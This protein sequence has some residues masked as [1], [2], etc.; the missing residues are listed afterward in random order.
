MEKIKE[1]QSTVLRIKYFEQMLQ[2]K[3]EKLFFLI[4]KEEYKFIITGSS[5]IYDYYPKSNKILDRNTN[6]W[7]PDG[8][9]YIESELLK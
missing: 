1:K 9:A 3:L 4:D 7:H 8:A 5:G 2:P 6:K